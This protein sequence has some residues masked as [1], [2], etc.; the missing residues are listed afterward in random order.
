MI[1]SDIFGGK[2]GKINSDGRHYQV[3][4]LFESAVS[5][6]AFQRDIICCVIKGL[7][8][9]AMAASLMPCR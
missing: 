6:A 1:P 9:S 4:A 5:C 7:Q 2:N 8:Q 3:P